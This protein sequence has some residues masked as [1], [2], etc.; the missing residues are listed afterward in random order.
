M[1]KAENNV[2]GLLIHRHG[3]L[4]LDYVYVRV[5]ALRK[6]HDI[7]LFQALTHKHRST[8]LAQFVVNISRYV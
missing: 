4:C 1:A 7:R 3:N 8:F 5:A 2:S 6:V